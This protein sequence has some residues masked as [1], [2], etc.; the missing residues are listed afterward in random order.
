M[1]V[2]DGPSVEMGL[3]ASFEQPLSAAD[4]ERLLEGQGAGPD[5]PEERQALA[6]MLR[7][8]A[9]P[10][11]PRELAG[12]VSA[13]AVFALF[14]EQK[15]RRARARRPVLAACATAAIA[16]ALSGTAA[17]DALP[18]PVQRVAHDTFGAP[19]PRHPAPS[20]NPSPVGRRVNQLSATADATPGRPASAKIPHRK[21]KALGKEK[22]LGKVKPPKPKPK[23]VAHGLAKG[24]SAGHGHK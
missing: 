1:S 4:A 8:A 14:K 24:H 21:G 13:V 7:H 11:S 2:D 20:V 5:A 12:E 17:A 6:M 19:A 3:F 15:T 18:A 10:A 9:G 23:P 22:A 16:I